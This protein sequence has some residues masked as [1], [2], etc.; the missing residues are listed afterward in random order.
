MFAGHT[1]IS[2]ILTYRYFI[3]FPL[4]CFEGPILALVVGF[5][6][7]LG[8]F[9]VIPA[10]LLMC[11][12]DFLPDIFYYYI[13]HFGNQKNFLEKYGARFKII[14]N[15]FPTIQKLWFDHSY[16]MMFFS[17]LAYGLSTPLLISAGLA[18]MPFRKFVYQALLVTI[19]QYSIIL[20]L[21]YYLGYSYTYA[22]EYIKLT[23]L[24]LAIALIVFIYV[25]IR[26]Q[27][28]AKREIE[29]LEKKEELEEQI[30]I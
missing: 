16:K 10:F 3:L 29:N 26:I 2:L 11:A 21:G 13:G 12:G 17:K 20:T 7:H 5:L 25:Y 1:I 4:A 14:K 24:I 19:F 15:N 6:I 18:K 23:G 27:K 8:Y 9:S 22:T 30:K 28:Y